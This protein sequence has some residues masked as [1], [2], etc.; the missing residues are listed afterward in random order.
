MLL[1]IK[2]Y[3]DNLVEAFVVKSWENGVDVFR[4]FDSL[5][6]MPNMIKSIE[7][8][9]LHTKALAEVSKCYTVDIQNPTRKKYSLSYYKQ[10]AKD[11][12]NS[13]A[14]IL[15]IKDMS[16]LLK[17]W[18][19]FEL[20]S[21]L[22]QTVRLPI[23]LHTHDTSSLQAATYLKAIEAGVDVVDGWIGAI[24]GLTSQPN[25]NA[26]VE[27]MKFHERD[28]PYNMEVLNRH[29]AYWE[30]V[31][32]YYYPFESGMKASSAEVYYH[33]IPGGQYSNLKPQAESLGW[34][35]KLEEIKKTYRDVNELFGDIIKITPSS[36]IVGDMALF[37]VTNNLT[38]DDI[39]EKGDHN[40]FLNPSS[41]FSVETLV[42]PWVGLTYDC[43]KLFL[44]TSRPIR[45]GP[46]EHLEPVDFDLEMELFKKKFDNSVSF[47]DLLS[48]LM[49][50]KV[51][52][53][54]YFKKKEYGDVSS[55]PT[56]NF[57]YG[58]SPDEEVLVEIAKGKSIL[59]RLLTFSAPDEEGKRKIFMRLN[60]Q[61][62]I[63]E[64]Q[65]KAILVTVKENLKAEKGNNKHI[66]APLQGKL[67]QL[68]VKEG[69]RVH[70][71]QPL[72]VIEAMK[73]E[74]TIAANEDG[75]IK[76]MV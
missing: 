66:G 19:A 10:F 43:K 18:A 41:L 25:L 28:N 71:N 65:D 46:N 35:N 33:E 51:F 30:N 70:R 8:V 52:E 75:I 1:V 14:H 47:T 27:M 45:N 39:M 40:I 32:E 67:S 73:M 53:E 17:L 23:H 6:W 68:L 34:G 74:T 63:I 4:I 42:N 37:M 54:F 44:K 49:Y 60:S 20:I 55:I 5:N 7:T 24:S 62:R 31:R 22:K 26:L 56:I 29:S 61:T 69:D 13:G 76:Q 2:S 21:E 57:F 11:I 59:V 15:A 16:G 72:F 3:R 12:E 50:P 36:K 58:L 38:V 64:V 9:R 48:Y